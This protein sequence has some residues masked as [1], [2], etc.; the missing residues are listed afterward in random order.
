MSV[1]GRCMY[2]TTGYCQFFSWGFFFTHIHT[3]THTY[4]HTHTKIHVRYIYKTTYRL[5]IARTGLICYT[6]REALCSHI[7]MQ[8]VNG[9]A[10][11]FRCCYYNA[12]QFNSG[13]NGSSS[14]DGKRAQEK[15]TAHKP[16]SQIRNWF[17]FLSRF[18]SPR[19]IWVRRNFDRRTLLIT[20]SSTRLATVFSTKSVCLFVHGRSSNDVS[21]HSIWSLCPPATT[22][23][24][25]QLT[26]FVD[27][28]LC[29]ILPLASPWFVFESHE[30]G[31]SHMD[32]T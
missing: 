8:K 3:H 17:N 20:S 11:V 26:Q 22:R 21:V 16:V 4:T 27:F 25:S 2:E 1:W 12:I 5:A 32:V 19:P 28:V 23:V 13:L 6:K 10:F 14:S 9:K 31:H 18:L 15:K 24:W 7:S 29:D 30:L